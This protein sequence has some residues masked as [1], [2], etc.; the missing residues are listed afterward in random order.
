MA[1]FLLQQNQWLDNEKYSVNLVLL[2]KKLLN[3][4]LCGTQFKYLLQLL[5]G[6]LTGFVVV[7]I[8]SWWLSWARKFKKVS[9]TCLG[10]WCYWVG[11]FNHPL[12]SLSFHVVPWRICYFSSRIAWFSG[13]H[14][15]ALNISVHWFLS[16]K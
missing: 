7:A 15:P 8:F 6:M 3:K 1:P 5:P 11:Y 2:N 4:E 13:Y 16:E 14:V 9:L 12:C 10:L